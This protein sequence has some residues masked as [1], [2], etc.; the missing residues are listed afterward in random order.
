MTVLLG[1][2]TRIRL[3]RLL[4]I[5]DLREA[6]A[7]LPG[8]VEAALSG[9][10]DVLQLRDPAADQSALTDGF[11]NV[12]QVVLRH[13]A[14]LGV[15]DSLPVAEAV[16]SDLLQ[17][18]ERGMDASSAR[19]RLHEYALVG[20]SCHSRREVDAALADSQVDYLMVGPVVGGLPLPGSGL[21]LVR[22]AAAAAPPSGPDSKPWFAVGGITTEN[23]DEVLA[24]GAR[25]IAVSSAI[26]AAEDPRASA[27]ALTARLAQAWKDDPGMERVVF[28]AFGT[29][30]GTAPASPGGARP[31]APRSSRPLIDQAGPDGGTALR[32]PPDSPGLGQGRAPQA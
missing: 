11:T 22:H 28:S 25:R 30:P 16:K 14:L 24:A 15:Y 12:R 7:D 26:T 4:L 3:A 32:Q 13:R 1:V 8:F 31:V 18:S 10:V 9:G 17:L 23:L 19:R 5:T 27:Q 21:D 20:R 6:Q 2:A 29:N